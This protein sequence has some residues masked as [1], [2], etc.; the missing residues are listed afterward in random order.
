ML[1]I[2]SLIALETEDA[3]EL[4]TLQEDIEAFDAE[5][6]AGKEYR[7]T[8]GFRF[9][10]LDPL[11]GVRKLDLRHYFDSEFCTCPDGLRREYPDLLLRGQ[12]EMSFEEAVA[13]IRQARD[14]G[15]H[16]MKA[17]LQNQL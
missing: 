15:W 1:R 7:R 17:D 6:T 16:A 4:E 9:E 14:R 8:A 2:I 12:R 5:L 11:S 10:A 3:G 13:L